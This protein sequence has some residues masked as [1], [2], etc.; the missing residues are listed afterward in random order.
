MQNS[1]FFGNFSFNIFMLF[2][3]IGIWCFSSDILLPSVIEILIGVWGGSPV[4]R[5]SRLDGVKRRETE[6]G[7]GDGKRCWQTL[8]MRK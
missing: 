5:K 4:P 3:I 7:R 8:F 6:A 1:N 2:L